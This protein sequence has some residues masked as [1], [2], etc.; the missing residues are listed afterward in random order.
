MKFIEVL[1][2]KFKL[3]S[4]R[5]EKEVS[6]ELSYK[7]S[8]FNNFLEIICNND[9]FFASQVNAA[10]RDFR[11]IQIE[12]ERYLKKLIENGHIDTHDYDISSQFLYYNL[13][14]DY[15]FRFEVDIWRFDSGSLSKFIE[16]EINLPFE[17]TLTEFDND[18]TKVIEKLET[19]SAYTLLNIESKM[20][21]YNL[22]LCQKKEKERILE[23]AQILELP[24]T[25]L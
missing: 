3:F 25:E 18:I 11:L 12:P 4:S 24:I 8:L 21:N 2:R 14:A 22:F 19:F 13:L 23:L 5:Y 6:L 10:K 7:E 17:I 16:V 9:C 1:N 15:V 20:D